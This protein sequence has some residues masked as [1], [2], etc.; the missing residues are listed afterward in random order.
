VYVYG[1]PGV[2]KVRLYVQD[3]AVIRRIQT[4]LEPHNTLG[5]FVLKCSYTRVLCGVSMS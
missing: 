1:V 3:V 5:C 4:L 2:L